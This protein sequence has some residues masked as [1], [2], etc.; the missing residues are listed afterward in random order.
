M[1]ATDSYNLLNA[2]LGK[3]KKG[4]ESLVLQGGS[5]SII[6]GNWK[7]IEPNKGEA[8]ATLVNIETGNFP[9]PQ[10]YDLNKDIGE[11]NNLA[12]QYPD[13]VK[14]LSDLLNEVKRIKIK[15]TCHITS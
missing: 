7:Y 15:D 12:D 3:S 13:K 11:K 2:L 10:L 14:E 5:L 4:R 1:K 9:G 8:V 6:K